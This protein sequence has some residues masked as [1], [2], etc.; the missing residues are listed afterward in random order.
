[1]SELSLT[2]TR[3]NTGHFGG[4]AV[5]GRLTSRWHSVAVSNSFITFIAILNTSQDSFCVRE[6]LPVPRQ[7]SFTVTRRRG[8]CRWSGWR[9][10]DDRQLGGTHLANNNR[11]CRRHCSVALQFRRSVPTAAAR[12]RKFNTRGECDVI[13]SE[14]VTAAMLDLGG[15]LCCGSVTSWT[16]TCLQ[17][18]VGGIIQSIDTV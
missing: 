9:C 1:M 2:P 5:V 10:N 14:I 18:A 3:H 8:G 12:K 6:C 7:K 4:G 16:Y 17:T 11:C 13:L 15:M